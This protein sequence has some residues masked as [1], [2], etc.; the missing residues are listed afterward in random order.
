MKHVIED[1]D[2]S[3]TADPEFSI[4]SIYETYADILE[5]TGILHVKGLLSRIMGKHRFQYASSQDIRDLYGWSSWDTVLEQKGFGPLIETTIR[6]RVSFKHYQKMVSS[7]LRKLP[8]YDASQNLHNMYWSSIDAVASNLLS[9]RGFNMHSKEYQGGLI[10]QTFTA[11][12]GLK[13]SKPYQPVHDIYPELWKMHGSWF[14]GKRNLLLGDNFVK[15][16]EVLLPGICSPHSYYYFGTKFTSFP[17][18]FEDFWLPSVNF[19]LQ[20]SEKYWIGLPYSE[21]RRVWDCIKVLSDVTGSKPAEKKFLMSPDIIYSVLGY[22]VH[23]VHQMPGDV[24]ISAAG[25]THGGFNLGN[26]F[27][28]AVNFADKEGSDGWTSMYT[29]MQDFYINELG[30]GIPNCVKFFE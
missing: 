6:E 19:L 7:E 11:Y 1:Y 24:V 4:I 26:N 30:K 23:E 12:Y 21:T 27:A 13:M 14:G 25:A 9:T 16:G 10:P 22:E 3:V 28:E 8:I 5:K 17:H 15:Q 2:R 20:G 29:D 18:H